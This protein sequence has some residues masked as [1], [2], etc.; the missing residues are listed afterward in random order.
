MTIEDGET[1]NYV[2]ISRQTELAFVETTD[3]KF[4]KV[5]VIPGKMLKK[6]GLIQNDELPVYVKVLRYME[7]SSLIDAE[8][9]EKEEGW[10]FTTVGGR[11]LKLVP[12]TEESGA[13]TEGKADSAAIHVQFLKKNTDEVLGELGYSAAEIAGFRNAGAI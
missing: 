9:G 11:E 12:R 13:S 1:A 5:S 6:E 3:S 10:T 4:D 7:N 2:D 8:D